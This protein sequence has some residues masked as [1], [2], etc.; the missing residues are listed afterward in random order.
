[1]IKQPSAYDSFESWWQKS[2]S[3]YEAAVLER[4]GVPWALSAEGRERVA[5]RLGVSPNTDPMDLRRALWERGHTNRN[6]AA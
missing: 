2:G 1:M 3:R 5:A 6:E 4:G